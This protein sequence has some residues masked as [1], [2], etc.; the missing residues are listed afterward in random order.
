MI[1]PI[2]DAAARQHRIKEACQH[3]QGEH[4]VTLREGPVQIPTVHLDQELLVY[5]V[6]N[7]RLLAALQE[8]FKNQPS[9][10]KQLHRSES[11]ASTQDLL[12]ALLL[13]KAGDQ[14]G[15]ILRELKRLK[16]QTEPL[17]VD[18]TGVVVNGNR[19]LSAMRQ[20]QKEDPERFHRFQKPLVA[21]L[22][23]E[24]SRSDVEYIETA[25][26]LAPETKLPYGWV[27]RRL[28][29][30]RQI[31]DLGLDPDWVQ[32]AYRLDSRQQLDDELAELALVERYLSEICGTPFAYSA[33][34]SCERLFQSLQRQL[35]LLPTT[36]ANA[37]TA[38]GLLLI[39]QRSK[40]SPAFDR[41]FPFEVPITET[42]P[43]MVLQRLANDPGLLAHPLHKPLRRKHIKRMTKRIL[44]HQTP[45]ELARTVETVIDEVRQ[46][47]RQ[48]R[49]PH[50]LLHHLHA[51]KRL[52][53]KLTPDQLTDAER[54][55]LL[56]EANTIRG[57]LDLLISE[58]KNTTQS[59]SAQRWWRGRRRLSN[60]MK[61]LVRDRGRTS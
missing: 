33:V 24:I 3:S 28:K 53:E 57:R 34:V 45:A 30:R 39:N 1:A 43:E 11:A 12:H 6:D 50:R 54:F 14:R 60:V 26:Q 46:Q 23:E 5:R 58:P 25:L 27:D 10:L 48:D 51:S 38:I 55:N 17:L 9:G 61:R 21:V 52:L 22:P 56:T 32:E 18:S 49:V 47:L 59:K 29:L 42:M 2:E 13:V 44:H 37:W 19:R 16:V 31:D 41:Q 40:L 4:W 36:L 8:H 20:L 7:G 15:P 35:R